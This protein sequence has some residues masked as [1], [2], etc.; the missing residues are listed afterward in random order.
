M[1]VGK[2]LVE[3]IAELTA[4][5]GEIAWDSTKLDGQPRR[6]LDASKAEREFGF[7]ARPAFGK[8]FGGRL[9]GI[10]SVEA[11]FQSLRILLD[12][13]SPAGEKAVV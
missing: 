8:D 12:R 11:G 2:E 5:D 10:G 1:L 6:C 7:K 4:F 3:T 13:P 9:S